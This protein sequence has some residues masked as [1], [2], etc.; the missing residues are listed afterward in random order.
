MVWRGDL[1][2]HTE[3]IRLCPVHPG[4]S[5]F[6][7]LE[8]SEGTTEP[9]QIPRLALPARGEGPYFP[10]SLIRFRFPSPVSKSRPISVSMF[11]NTP[12]TFIM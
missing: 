12:I 8:R 5:G 1:S 10:P 4:K 11:M 2:A 6:L 3:Q 9:V 7:S